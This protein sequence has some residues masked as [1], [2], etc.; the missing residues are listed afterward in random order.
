MAFQDVVPGTWNM[1]FRGPFDQQFTS[2]VLKTSTGTPADLSSWDTYTCQL[3][4]TTLTPASG[5]PISIGIVTGDNAGV[6]T[7]QVDDSAVAALK[8]AG[9]C[10][11]V[12]FGKKTSGDD[13]QILTDGVL[14]N[15]K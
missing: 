4:P 2:P 15:I 7:L 5:D 8:A 3:S 9:Q 14:T 12:T 10:R 1:T 13:F 11:V 6:L